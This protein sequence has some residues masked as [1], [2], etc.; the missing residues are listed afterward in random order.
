MFKKTKAFLSVILAGVMLSS[1][2]AKGSSSSEDESSSKAESTTKAVV[3]L[4]QDSSSAPE[5]DSNSEENAADSGITPLM[6]K[7]TNDEGNELILIGS[8]HALADECYPLPDRV[9]KAYENA[10]V[11]ACE[12][13]AVTAAND[14]AKQL[15]IMNQ[16]TYDDSAENIALH[17]SKETVDGLTSFFEA[18]GYSMDSLKHYKPWYISLQCDNMIMA[19]CGLNSQ[20]GLDNYILQKAHEDGK[21]IYEVESY[22]FQMGMLMNFSDELY[23]LLLSEYTVENI[24]L[25]K[26]NL[27]K[28]YELWKKGDIKE[29]ES[30]VTQADEATYGE[31]TDKQKELLDEYNKLFLY[32]RNEGMAESAEKLLKEHKNTFFMVGLA[33]FIGDG[34]IVDLLEK[35]GYTVEQI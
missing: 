24:E 23:D 12:L 35:K 22:D 27:T 33:H 6:W 9:M 21:E 16:S 4:P 10:E 31:L 29:T 30:Y 11:I 20:V 18:E 3:T 32:D 17:L 34:G 5:E 25:L 14:L 2:A 15:E 19:Q 1:C 7:V 13:D 28:T 8:M 26:E